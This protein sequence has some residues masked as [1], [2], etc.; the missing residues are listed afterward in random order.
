MV[1]YQI[2]SNSRISKNTMS[3]ILTETRNTQEYLY[4]ESGETK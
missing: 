3:R 2:S 4:A 1:M